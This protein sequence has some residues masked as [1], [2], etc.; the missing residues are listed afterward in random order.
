SL[1]TKT[2]KKKIPIVIKKIKKQLTSK[3]LNAN[4]WAYLD[5]PVIREHESEVTA[6]LYAHHINTIVVHGE[7]IPNIGDYDFNELKN[8]LQYY[9]HLNQAKVLLFKNS[10]HQ[11]LRRT[12]EGAKFLTASWKHTFKEIGR[13]SCRERVSIAES[14]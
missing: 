2:D 4:V 12:V 5:Y 13:A 1:Q 14:E 11:S 8:Y 9:E 6:D 10:I 7:Y 3:K